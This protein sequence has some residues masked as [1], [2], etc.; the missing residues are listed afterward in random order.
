MASVEELL[1]CWVFGAQHSKP[2]DALTGSLGLCVYGGTR[3]SRASEISQ[4]LLRC[5]SINHRGFVDNSVNCRVNDLDPA[6]N[7]LR[8][9]KARF[10][11]F[12]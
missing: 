2:W 8:A 7:I 12:M 9:T 6:L 11:A 5:R 4:T 1:D 3:D 10:Y